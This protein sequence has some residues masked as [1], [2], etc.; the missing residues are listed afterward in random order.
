M[1]VVH[2]PY[3]SFIVVTG[4]DSETFLQNLITS[5]IQTLVPGITRNAALLTPQGKVLF[6]FLINKVSETYFLLETSVEQCNELIKR[7]LMYRL[8]SDITLERRQP[9]GVTIFW[10]KT[11]PP[12]LTI[13]LIDERFLIAGIQVYRV[14]ASYD[15]HVDNIELYHNLRIHHCIVEENFD[16]SLCSIYPHDIFMDINEGV[17]FTKGCYLG[18]EVVSRMKHRNAARKRPVIVTGTQKLPPRGTPIFADGKQVGILGTVIGNK[19]LAIVRIDH[20]S[21]ALVSDKPI[22]ANNLKLTMAL[23]EWSKLILPI[24]KNNI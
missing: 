21:E 15:E 20:V 23:P 8:R 17:S 3:R 13:S 5:E 9:D 11:A 14:H 7:F 24:K 12:D 4:K 18:Q 19:G 10:D 2:L 1:P 22:L 6:S 16:Y